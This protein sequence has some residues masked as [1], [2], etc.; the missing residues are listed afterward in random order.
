LPVVSIGNLTLGGTGK[1]PMVEHVCRRLRARD[2][3]VAIAS[4]GYGAG[5]GPNDEALVLED[6]LPDCPHL[7][8]PDRVMLARISVEELDAQILVLDDGFQHRRLARDLDIVLIDALDPFGGGRLFP[9]GLLR[10]PI[11]SLRRANLVVLSRADLVPASERERIRSTAE[12]HTKQRLDWVE[13]QHRPVEARAEGGETIPL[14]EL[15]KRRVVAFCGL[16][17]PAGFRRTLEGLGVHPID[18]R[19]FPD[20]HDYTRNDVTELSSWTRDQQAEVVL[21]TQ[22][23]WVKLRTPKLGFAQLLALRISLDVQ[24]GEE[25]I[26]DALDK[27]ASK[28]SRDATIASA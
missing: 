24:D 1:T 17:N 2:L 18:F 20:H 22:K 4:R 19:E 5:A 27:V 7:T 9:R 12:K 8:G 16:G 10:E 15:P 23:D 11:R 25:L 26:E 14:E 13:A 3:R 21:T 28:A 6:N